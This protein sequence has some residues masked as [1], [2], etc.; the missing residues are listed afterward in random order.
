VVK[1]ENYHGEESK[2]KN[3][4]GS[5]VGGIEMARKRCVPI[6]LNKPRSPRKLRG[7]PGEKRSKTGST[8][9]WPNP[10]SNKPTVSNWRALQKRKK[11][12]F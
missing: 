7:R 11:K 2:A 1:K 9:R 6:V 8:G 3:S 10:A 4:A 12:S 5:K